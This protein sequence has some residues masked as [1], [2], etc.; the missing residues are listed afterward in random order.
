[1]LPCARAART[2]GSRSPAMMASRMSRAVLVLDMECTA[3]DSLTSAPS[4]SFS[5]RCHSLVRSRTS[6]SLVRVRSRSARI[7][8]GGTNDGRSRPISASRA[9]HCAS[10]RPVFGRPASCRAW[11]ELTS[12]TA[13]PAASSR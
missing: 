7:S 13:S 6:I 11:R 2:F 9:S 4:S 1:M 10:S 12:W 8:G 5:S 3:E